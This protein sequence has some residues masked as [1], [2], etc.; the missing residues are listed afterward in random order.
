MLIVVA[1]MSQGGDAALAY[2]AIWPGSSR[3]LR[4]RRQSDRSGYPTS[5]KVSLKP[6]RWSP[7][8]A[9]MKPQALSIATLT[10]RSR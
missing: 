7:P 9:A 1:G 4:P 10:A 2:G 8:A 5:R 6:A 3:S